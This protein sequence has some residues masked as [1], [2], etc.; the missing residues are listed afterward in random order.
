MNKN[1]LSVYEIADAWEEYLITILPNHAFAYDEG[2]KY[3]RSE[4]MIA[5][6]HQIK[7][8]KSQ[9]KKNNYEYP[10]PPIIN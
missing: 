3:V 2:E 1:K 8:I 7:H 6:E 10:I 5:I 4:F 9:F